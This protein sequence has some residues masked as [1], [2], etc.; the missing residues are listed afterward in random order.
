MLGEPLSVLITSQRSRPLSLVVAAFALF[1][2]GSLTIFLSKPSLFTTLGLQGVLLLSIAISLPIVMLCF[3]IWY[4]P[5]AA[6]LRA[7]RIVEGIP[8][9]EGDIAKVMSADD[10]LEWPCLLNGSWT[11]LL[12]LYAIAAIAYRSPLRIGTTFLLTAAILFVVWVVAWVTSSVL[13]LLVQRRAGHSSAAVTL[14][15]GST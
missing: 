5:L 14:R 2:P 8:D 10:Q 15:G 9:P 1:V 13:F 4:T 11:A 12:V 7:Q 3:G 6:I